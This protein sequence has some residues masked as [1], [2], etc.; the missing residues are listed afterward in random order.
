[1]Q[2]D[3][4]PSSIYRTLPDEGRRRRLDRG[5]EKVE[6]PGQVLQKMLHLAVV[7]D[8]SG[9][10]VIEAAI[11]S[12][13]IEPGAI[14]VPTWNRYLAHRQMSRAQRDRHIEPFRRFE[15]AYSNQRHYVDIT[16]FPD[17]FVEA[18]GSIGYESTL[19]TSKNRPGNRKPRLQLFWLVDGHSRT[20]YG[21]FYYSKNTLNWLDFLIKAWTPKADPYGYPF[22]GRPDNVYSDKESIWFTPIMQRFLA[23]MEVHFHHHMPG[24]SQAKGKVERAI[25]VVETWLRHAFSN[26]EKVTLQQANVFLDDLLYKINGRLHGTTRQDPLS[27]WRT[28]LAG[29]NIRLMPDAEVSERFFYTQ[30]MRLI[31]GDMTVRIGGKAWQLPRRAPF[32]NYG[33]ETVPVFYHPGATA[34][35]SIFVVIE[36]VEYEI[37]HATPLADAAGEYR[38]LPQ[39]AQERLREQLEAVDVSDLQVGGF[40]EMYAQRAFLPAQGEEL[41]LEALA[42]PRRALGRLQLVE[43]LQGEGVIAAPPSAPDKAYIDALYAKDGQ[44]YEDDLPRIIHDLGGGQSYRA[45]AA[46]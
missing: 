35:R 33:G 11:L 17:Y 4:H 24:E 45:A 46:S 34:L 15:E 1:M 2:Y 26:M 29:R 3:V 8:L 43:R 27:R 21:R 10:E 37:E 38:Q 30:D 41:D 31:Q 22:Q 12:S 25:G 42:L 18:D 44:V 5:A 19:S 32:L 13:W 39:T 40:R 16:G 7:K 20:Q 6:V 36:D 23:A 14:S 9:P 28:G